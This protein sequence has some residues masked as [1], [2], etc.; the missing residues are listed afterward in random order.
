MPGVKPARNRTN[1]G[2]ARNCNLAVERAQG[3][4]VC[5]V[6]QDCLAL[7]PGWADAMLDVFLT[8]EN[9]GVVGP[10]LIFPPERGGGI[11]SCGGLF[12]GQKGPYHRF[13]GWRNIEDW[14]VSTTEPVSW[15]TGACLMV[16]RE[17]FVALGGFDWQTYIRGYF[18]DVDLCMKVRR[19]LEKTIW[20]CAEA[21][22]RHEVGSSGGNATHFRQNSVKFHARWDAHIEPD[23][24]FVYVDY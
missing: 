18:E 22:F 24:Q 15:V 4:Y 1:A 23:T 19:R 11:Q 12:D 21:C 3:E 16:R 20:Y 10:K 8:R 9:V 14:R 2:F 17:D 6:N 7:H 5:F 13:L